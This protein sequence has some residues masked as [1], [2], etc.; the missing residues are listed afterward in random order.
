MMMRLRKG[1]HVKVIAG[2]D[3]GKTGVIDNVLPHQNRVVVTGVNVLK[4]A[5]KATGKTKQ[6]GLVDFPAPLAASNVMAVDPKSGEPTKIGYRLSKD[7]KQKIR[8]AKKSGQ[9]LTGGTS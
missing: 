7:G 4:K 2:K 1:D 6:A 3:K 8:I 9:E 5:V